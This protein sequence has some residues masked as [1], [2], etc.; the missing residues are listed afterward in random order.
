MIKKASQNTNPIT[1]EVV[2]DP[3]VVA[4]MTRQ[5]ELFERNWAWLEANA[6][7]VYSHRG[8][9]ICIAGQELFVGDTV[10]QVLSAAKRAHPDDDGRFTRYIPLQR[11]PRVYAY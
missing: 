8:K 9:F 10:E 4:E 1:I 2:Y 6:S 5:K 7:E 11:G 3:T